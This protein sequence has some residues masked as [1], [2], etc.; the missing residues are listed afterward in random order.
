M[1]RL[2]SRELPTSIH[3]PKQQLPLTP[4]NPIRSNRLAG[5]EKKNKVVGGA[6]VGGEDR[7]SSRVIIQF[8][9]RGETL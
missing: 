6:G 5:K 7:T 3:L 1:A 2:T 9:F 8:G 4:S